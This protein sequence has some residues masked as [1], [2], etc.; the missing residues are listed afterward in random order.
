MDIQTQ[1]IHH[2]RAKQHPP[3]PWLGLAGEW[4]G[5][6]REPSGCDLPSEECTTM[7]DRG[8]QWRRGTSFWTA[9]P[10]RLSIVSCSDLLTMSMRKT[11]K[12]TL[13]VPQAPRG[14]GSSLL[15]TPPSSQR[16][17]FYTNSILFDSDDNI[18]WVCPDMGLWESPRAS[19]TTW[20]GCRTRCEPFSCLYS[21]LCLLFFEWWSHESD[22]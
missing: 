21:P 10:R 11:W 15:P 9:V 22:Q 14:R 13:W 17:A 8:L 12:M 20:R 1:R 19:E 2:E 16:T 3:F 7:I 5:A 18:Q 6:S 4:H